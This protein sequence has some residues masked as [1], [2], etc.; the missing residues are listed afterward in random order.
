MKSQDKE[1]YLILRKKAYASSTY[2]DEKTFE[3]TVELA[4]NKYRNYSMM[5]I[6]LP[7]YFKKSTDVDVVINC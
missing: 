7:T 5:M 3:F 6:V 2:T 1:K 4:A